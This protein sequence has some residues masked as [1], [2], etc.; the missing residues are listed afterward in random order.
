LFCIIASN[1]NATEMRGNP[2]DHT[3]AAHTKWRDAIESPANRASIIADAQQECR[4]PDIP[5]FL[6][7]IQKYLTQCGVQQAECLTL[8]LTNSVPSALTMLACMD[9]GYSVMAVPIEGHGARAVGS[10]FPTARFSR[11]IVTLK[12]GLRAEPRDLQTPSSYVEVRANPDYDASAHRP[13]DDARLYLR[14]SGS[15]GATKL[16]ARLQSR[17]FANVTDA[18]ERLRLGPSHRVVLPIPIFHAFGLGP[19]FLG[20]LTG[21]ASIDLQNRSNLLHY[22]E[23]ERRFAPNVAFVTPSFCEILVRGRRAPRPYEFM[24]TGGDRIS[25]AT[26]F[27]SEELHGP[28]INAYGSTEMGFIFSGDVDMPAEL[29][30]RTVGRPLPG[31]RIRIVERPDSA[32]S[33]VGSLQIQYPNGFEG[34]VD[35]DGRPLRPEGAYDAEW[36]CSADL[37]KQGPDGTLEVLGR[38]DLSVNRNGLLLAFADLESVLREVDGIEEAGVAAGPESIR[39]RKIVAFCALRRGSERSESELR[40]DLSSRVPPFAVPD[41]I[42]VVP[43]LPRLPNGKIDRRRLAAW[44]QMDNASGALQAS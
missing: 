26:F 33:A 27:R 29:R 35:L 6:E 36:Y 5:A 25:R 32:D 44:A 23:R 28:L 43:Q 19:A 41:R 4:Y 11:W 12:D 9:A 14:T 15:L 34:Y 1:K 24:V 37:A 20:S 3:P 21:G 31:V 38:S 39:G 30:F 13:N 42:R 8:E 18:R 40:A 2:P 7:A 10:E 16:V 17:F 22:L